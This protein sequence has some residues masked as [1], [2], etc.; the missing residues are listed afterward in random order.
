[1][2]DKWFNRRI[3]PGGH[4]SSPTN[5]GRRAAAPEERVRRPRRRLKARIGRVGRV[6]VESGVPAARSPGGLTA[7]LLRFG[8]PRQGRGALG[9]P[10]L[11]V[12]AGRAAGRGRA[13]RGPELLVPRLS[14]PQGRAGRLSLL[15]FF[16]PARGPDLISWVWGVGRRRR[17]CAARM[18]AGAGRQVRDAVR[19]DGPAPRPG[20]RVLR[21]GVVVWQ[22]VP[23]WA[24]QRW[25]AHRRGPGQS[26]GVTGDGPTSPI[27]TCRTHP[28]HPAL[29]PA[30]FCVADCTFDE[31]YGGRAGG[32][33]GWELAGALTARSAAD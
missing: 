23:P 12:A 30:N 4:F 6:C 22:G 29:P 28:A 20:L 33:G 24:M 5:A 11:G 1:M 21:A 19:G 3:R 31:V 18:E 26:H 2:L 25:R 10:R 14:P 13:Q 8:A 32:G 17:R 15:G 7:C 16:V 9:A 27:V